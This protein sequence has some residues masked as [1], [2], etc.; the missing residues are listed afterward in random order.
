MLWSGLPG[1]QVSMSP[2]LPLPLR[3][4]SAHST[5]LEPGED[6]KRLS[7]GMLESTQLS[8]FPLLELSQD[9]SRHFCQARWLQCVQRQ[10]WTPGFLA[11]SGPGSDFW[12]QG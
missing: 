1:A 12:Y 11:S 5:A 3:G 7:P 8:L 9:P 6:F 4:L 10:S 2:E